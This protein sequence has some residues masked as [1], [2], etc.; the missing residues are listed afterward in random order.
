MPNISDTGQ[1]K[2]T[3]YFS[4]EPSRISCCSLK[5]LK[6]RSLHWLQTLQNQT[7]ASLDSLRIKDRLSPIVSGFVQLLHILHF[8][9]CRKKYRPSGINWRRSS[10]TRLSLL[11]ERYRFL[12]KLVYNVPVI[13]YAEGCFYGFGCFWKRKILRVDMWVFPVIEHAMLFQTLQRGALDAF[14]N[15]DR[16]RWHG[17][18]WFQAPINWFVGKFVS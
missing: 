18:L 1:L 11:F 15:T 10:S 14:V 16:D 12:W 17:S 2:Q 3:V 9:Q 4:R 8:R 5:R 13:R 7:S 6:L